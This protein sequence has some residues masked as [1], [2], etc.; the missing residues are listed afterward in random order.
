MRLKRPDWKDIVIMIETFILFLLL[1]PFW[2]EVKAF[3]SGIFS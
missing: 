2:D 1:F 3:I